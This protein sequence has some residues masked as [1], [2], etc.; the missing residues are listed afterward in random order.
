[1]KRSTNKHEATTQ[2][3]KVTSKRHK[4]TLKTCNTTTNRCKV[5][6]KIRKMATKRHIINT[7]VDNECKKMKN[8]QR[9]AQ[10]HRRVA[11]RIHPVNA[12]H[13]AVT[14]QFFFILRDSWFSQGGENVKF[15]V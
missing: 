3:C 15:A 7:E 11:R 2:R 6:R 10:N 14:G 4:M 1:M 12:C 13:E 8:E 5:T 9:N